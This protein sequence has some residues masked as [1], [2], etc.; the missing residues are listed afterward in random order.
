MKR[1]EVEDV[2]GGKDAWENVDKADGEFC[3]GLGFIAIAFERKGGMGERSGGGSRGEGEES[4]IGSYILCAQSALLPELLP[5][6][7]PT[8]KQRYLLHPL[9]SLLSFSPRQ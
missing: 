3:G 2:I 6:P 4:S 7:L 9:P 1:K 5:S 8:L